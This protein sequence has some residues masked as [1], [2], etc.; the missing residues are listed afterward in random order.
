MPFLPYSKSHIPTYLAFGSF[1]VSGWLDSDALGAT[2]VYTA[3]EASFLLSPCMRTAHH[4]VIHTFH[5]F[6]LLLLLLLLLEW[7]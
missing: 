1:C 5:A 6:F 2:E 4:S 7:V 3:D